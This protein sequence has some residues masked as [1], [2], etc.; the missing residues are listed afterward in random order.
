MVTLTVAGAQH[1][2]ADAPRERMV[3]RQRGVVHQDP[4]ERARVSQLVDAW[5]GPVA[6]HRTGQQRVLDG[7][8]N[9]DGAVAAA[10][11]FVTR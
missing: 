1:P 2:E 8:G 7:P 4:V 10:D 6:G 9:R 5:I 11:E 3:G